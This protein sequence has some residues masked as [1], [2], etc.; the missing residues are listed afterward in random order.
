MDKPSV[1]CAHTIGLF[2]RWARPGDKILDIGCGS[3]EM[4]YFLE[5]DS[6]AFIYNVD[7]GDFRQFKTKYFQIYNGITL[8][9]KD[10]YFDLVSFNFVLHHIPDKNKL[11]LLKEA[12]R[13]SKRC[14]F[15]LEDT[16]KNP[17]DKIISYRHGLYWQKKI[18]SKAGFGFYSQRKWEEFFKSLG[19]K[20]V[21]SQKLGRFCRKKTVPFA[22]SFF[23]LKKEN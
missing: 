20:I 13:V 14:L 16:P 1:N 22:R 23:L 18:G 2:T 12:K 19:L 4:S 15:I 5:K 10:S 7:I 6:Y 11:L 3:A 17:I 8:P 21:I 9:F